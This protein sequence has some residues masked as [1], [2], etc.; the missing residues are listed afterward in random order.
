[1]KPYQDIKAMFRSE[2]DD[3]Y[4]MRIKELETKNLKLLNQLMQQT[5]QEDNEG[6]PVDKGTLKED[7]PKDDAAEW[8]LRNVPGKEAV[9]E[10]VPIATTSEEGD[11]QF[12]L[13]KIG[14]TVADEP[15]NQNIAE[16]DSSL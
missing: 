10:S 12:Q 16:G 11:D 15:D 1:M 7:N 6:I 4:L 14:K 9:E 5:L 8:S 13:I 3:E 2:V